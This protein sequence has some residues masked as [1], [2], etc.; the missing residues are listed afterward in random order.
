MYCA[1][2]I[3]ESTGLVEKYIG[4][5]T[6]EGEPSMNDEELNEMP[7]VQEGS[8]SSSLDDVKRFVETNIGSK[9]QLIKGDFRKKEV[10]KMCDMYTPISIAV[11]DCNIISSIAS[12]LDYVLKNITPGGIIFIDDFYTNLANGNPVIDKIVTNS[13][14]SSKYRIINHGFYPPFG[15]SFVAARRS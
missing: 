14:N 1:H 4:L 7:Y 12:S 5:D 11:I 9:S 15:R 6:F 2:N 13:F 10:I 3:L 8:F